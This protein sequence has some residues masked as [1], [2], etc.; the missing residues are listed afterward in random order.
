M[1][2]TIFDIGADMVALDAIIGDAGGDLSDPAVAAAIEQWE[3]EIE[4]DLAGKVDRY[5]SLI[6]EMEARASKRREEA[7]RLVARAEQDERA[8]NG[9]RERLRLVWEARGLGVIQ[10]P[11]YRVALRRNGGKAPLDLHDV[12]PSEWTRTITSVGPDKDR[13]REALERGE[14]LTFAR[15]MERGNRISI[16]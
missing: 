9:L 2:R 15:L 8:A 1:S 16:T 13:I 14:Q 3:R 12:I 7:L 11:R 4:T 5:A 10:T 6:G